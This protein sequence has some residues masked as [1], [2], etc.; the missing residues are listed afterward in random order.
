MDHAEKVERLRKLVTSLAGAEGMEMADAGAA[1]AESAES[2][3]G[4]EAGRA[5]KAA[6]ALAS[7][8]D[9]PDDELYAL[10]AIILTKDRPAIDVKGSSFEKPIPPWDH[11]GSGAPRENLKRAIRSVGRVGVPGHPSIPYGGTGFVVGDGLLMTNRHVAAFF[12]EGLGLR[13]LDFT[14]GRGADIDFRKERGSEESIRME[15]DRVVMVHPYWDMALLKVDG[16]GAEQEPLELAV[17]DPDDLAGREIA[18]IGYPAPDARNDQTLQ[19]RIFGGVYYVKRLQPGKLRPSRGTTSFGN[20]VRAVTHDSSTLGGNSGSAVVDVQSGRV[21]ALHFKGMYLDANFA[22]PMRELAADGV[23]AD[24]G[25]NFQGTV[26]RSATTARAWSM[27]SGGGEAPTPSSRDQVGEVVG[28]LSWTWPLQLTVTLAKGEGPNVTASM[29]G[30]RDAAGDATE[31]LVEP[32]IDPQYS[33]RKGY[34]PE[35]LGVALP[36]PSPRRVSLVSKT[37]RAD[38]ALT[39]EHF[40]IVMHAKRRMA[41][42]TASNVSGDAKSR[43]PEPGEYSRD[44]LTGIG[45]G[46]QEKWVTDPRIPEWHQLPDKFYT[47]DRKAF[48]KGHIVRREDVC[49]GRTRNQIVKANNDTFHTT[50]CSPQVKG[51]NQSKEGGLWGELENHVLRLVKADKFSIF[52]GP[53]FSEDDRPFEGKDR[54]GA[55][56]IQIPSRYWKIIVAKNGGRLEA[57]AFV[58]EQDL[59]KVQFEEAFEV[60]AD[61][62]PYHVSIRDLQE[63]L[64]T[65]RFPK[66]LLDADRHDGEE[67][68]A[69]AR[70]AGIARR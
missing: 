19:D 52:A 57:F 35:F 44:A 55:V 31:A 51:F 50:N 37:D 28:P 54:R 6:R 5:A 18:L 46:N 42:F 59:S 62:R 12:T 14:P 38:H 43:R 68:I 8:Q 45:E 40:S 48:D 61:W 3:G 23:V 1:Y 22:V 25:L 4:G 53:V 15:V 34:D 21:V 33:N 36:M 47:Y 11:L 41:L 70:S 26:P 65:V 67:G 69:L 29:A 17:D 30:A 7:G 2:L 64:G 32:E 58:L 60:G 10:E 66:V 24:V 63:E 39:Y 56:R 20:T 27:A 13:R 9:A 16:L 49:W